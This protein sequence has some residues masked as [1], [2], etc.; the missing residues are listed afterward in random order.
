MCT[1]NDNSA[2]ELRSAR[3][4]TAMALVAMGLVAGVSLTSWRAG[5]PRTP[6]EEPVF[7]SVQSVTAAD[8]SSA[9]LV[10]TFDAGVELAA[11]HSGVVTSLA[12]VDSKLTHGDVA[13]TI[14][15]KP[16]VYWNSEV[17]PYRDLAAIG[18]TGE[19]VSA[20]KAALTG[21]GYD[22]GTGDRLDGQALEAIKQFNADRG[23]TGNGLQYATL[24]WSP[25]PSATVA[26]QTTPIGRLV[27]VNDSVLRTAP[28]VSQVSLL[29]SEAAGPARQFVADDLVVALSGIA[30]LK[31]KVRTAL[32]SVAAKAAENA[33]DRIEIE[34]RT[35]L[36]DP[37]ARA[38]VPASSVV[39]QG[40]DV[41]VWVAD[42]DN[43]VEAQTVDVVGGQP[44][45]ALLPAHAFSDQVSVVANP[46][47][48]SRLRTC[49]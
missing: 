46:T 9:T 3:V 10:V 45:L 23:I 12:P 29:P 11:G 8:E 15:E 44:G 18:T 17:P 2:P 43:Q 32:A 41:C 24:V 13:A 42:G 22:A 6:S 33:Q 48:I 14:D 37:V 47:E 39:S 36:V 40:G 30:E 34:G 1:D 7:V 25:N 21:L 19:D 4:L 16:Q 20:A 31:P 27:G 49:P 5:G 35:E 38:A 26:E 28:S